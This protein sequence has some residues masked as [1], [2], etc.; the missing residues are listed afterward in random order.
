MLDDRICEARRN[1]LR[2][3]AD[4][5]C[6]ELVLWGRRDAVGRR[7][8][9][10]VDAGGGVAR[11]ISGCF[12]ER[13]VGWFRLS[14]IVEA[15]VTERRSEGVKVDSEVEAAGGAVMGCGESELEGSGEG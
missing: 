7:L 11:F 3:R 2:D 13:A 10:G 6:R 9:I 4:K 12:E 5:N 1:E 14:I 15:L 8:G